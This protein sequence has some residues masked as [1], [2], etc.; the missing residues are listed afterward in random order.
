MNTDGPG[1]GGNQVTSPGLEMGRKGEDNVVHEQD[2]IARQTERLL[3]ETGNFFGGS[4]AKAGQAAGEGLGLETVLSNLVRHLRE[5][6]REPGAF[7]G[8]EY[9][10][11]GAA[12]T[13]ARH[14]AAV[15]ITCHPPTGRAAH[16]EPEMNLAHLGTPCLTNIRVISRGL[17]IMVPTTTACPPTAKAC[18]TSSGLL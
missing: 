8:V 17:V 15:S 1:A 16:V 5:H 12:D 6:C 13:T 11:S 14:N 18:K 9:V 2:R 7:G 10:G 4:G 3:G